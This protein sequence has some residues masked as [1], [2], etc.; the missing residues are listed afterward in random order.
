VL[1]IGVVAAL[2]ASPERY[3]IVKSCLPNSYNAPILQ[4]LDHVVIVIL[5][6]VATPTRTSCILCLSSKIPLRPLHKLLH[7]INRKWCYGMI[8]V[9]IR[10]LGNKN[11]H[12]YKR[13]APTMIFWTVRVA[14]VSAALSSAWDSC[15]GAEIC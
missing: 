12:K 8:L 14:S 9:T 11:L 15:G 10:E 13:T 7:D 6:R 1:L 3:L 5:Y 4:S 2:Y